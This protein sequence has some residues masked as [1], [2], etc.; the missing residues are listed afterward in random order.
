MTAD[1]A[2]LPHCAE[3]EQVFIPL[4]RSASHS[5]GNVVSQRDRL[6]CPS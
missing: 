2:Q 3:F 5:R 1:H 4:P 6:E